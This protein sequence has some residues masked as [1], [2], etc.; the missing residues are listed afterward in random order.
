M[1]LESIYVHRMPDDGF[2]G[3]AKVYVGDLVVEVIL[4]TEECIRLV[5]AGELDMADAHERAKAV[6]RGAMEAAR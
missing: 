5:R 6:V 3:I 4:K 2:Y 1:R